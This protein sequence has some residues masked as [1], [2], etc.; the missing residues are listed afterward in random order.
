MKYQISRWLYWFSAAS[1]A[2]ATIA[3]IVLLI[4]GENK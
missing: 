1:H 3:I 4:K 2:L